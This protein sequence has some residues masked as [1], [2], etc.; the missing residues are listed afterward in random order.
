MNKIY[1]LTCLGTILL[2]TGCAS[3]ISDTTYSVSISSSQEGAPFSVKNEDGVTVATGTTPDIVSLKAY[4]GFFDGATYTI[5]SG[6]ASTTLDSDLDEWYW[7]NIIFG[8]LIGML[9]VDPATGAMWELPEHMEIEVGAGD[10]GGNDF[11]GEPD[12]F[13]N[14]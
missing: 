2:S 1:F 4:A 13:W 5:E 6:S 8:G 3:I 11:L 10:F 12:D 7:G 9:I 14:E